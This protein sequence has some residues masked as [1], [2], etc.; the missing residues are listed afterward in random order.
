[1]VNS[2]NR[3]TPVAMRLRRLADSLDF[4]FDESSEAQLADLAQ[5]VGLADA[6]GPYRLPDP[7]PTRES[8]ELAMRL[9]AESLEPLG[10]A[11][12]ALGGLRFGNGWQTRQTL[13][14][15][16]GAGSIG[17]PLLGACSDDAMTALSRMRVASRIDRFAQVRESLEVRLTRFLAIEDLLWDLSAER[18]GP[19]RPIPYGYRYRAIEW[20]WCPQAHRHEGAVAL[21]LR[22]G[23]VFMPR[24]PVTALAPLCSHCAK[25]SP[26]ARRPP[27]HAIEPAERGTWWL[28]CAANECGNRF[29]GRAQARWCPPCRSSRITPRRRMLRR[30]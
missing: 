12:S 8:S 29:V 11:L 4:F 7:P 20:L 1:L 24:R 21:C 25:E 17:L 3:D 19:T 9:A 18:G 5:E 15:L 22:C 10:R 26:R 6:R 2:E 14:P 27:P 30:A 28:R 13:E 16:E 23:A